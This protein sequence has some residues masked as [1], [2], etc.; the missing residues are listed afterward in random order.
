MTEFERIAQGVAPAMT[1][2][3]DW[4]AAYRR[5]AAG[6]PARASSARSVMGGFVACVDARTDLVRATAL[7]ADDAP[8][9]AAQLGAALLARA[10]RGVGGEM[11]FEW[12]EG[13]AWLAE[14]L[15]LRCSLGGT[16]P[17]AAWVLSAIGAP[18]V[19]AL[20]DRSAH[21]LE[22]LPPGILAYEDGRLVLSEKLTARG[23]RQ[24][25]IYIFDYS[26]GVPVA[27]VVPPRSSRII[28]RLADPG[29]DRDGDFDRLSPEIAGT[30]G[31]GLISGF[32]AIPSAD[33]A[34]GVERVRS[35]C[36]SWREKGLGLIHLEMAGYET[37]EAQQDVLRAFAGIVTSLGMSQSELRRLVPPGVAAAEAMV[38]LGEQLGVRRVCVHADEWAASVTRDDPDVE[39]EAL[40]TGSLLAA[41]RAEAGRPVPEIALPAAARLD[42]P[43]FDGARVPAGWRFVAVPTPYLE[44]PASTLGLGDTFT[45]GCLMVLGTVRRDQAAA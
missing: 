42:P 19:I 21:M 18:S 16:G 39:R 9:R 13:A 5:L 44:R 8:P 34:A 29:L 41:A 33:F 17:Q 43:P 26:A 25:D 36:L 30:V 37:D 23:E 10:G 15:D 31:A 6:L 40:M 4:V 24:G 27:G 22:Q 7:F 12:P 28:V 11:L 2:A 38:A 14:Q 20:G 32:H 3:E 45:G 1:L 35:L